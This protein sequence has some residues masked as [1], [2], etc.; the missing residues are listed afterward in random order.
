[1]D[2]YQTH[3]KRDIS[4]VP[5]IANAC[6]LSALYTGSIAAPRSHAFM[7]GCAHRHKTI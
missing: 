2:A 6:R 1:M 4:V 5:V 7:K 3:A